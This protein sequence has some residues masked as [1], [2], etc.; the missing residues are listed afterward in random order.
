[1]ATR[2]TKLTIRDI[3]R[4]AGVSR[5]T[6]SLVINRDDRISQGTR[7]HVERV[8]ARSGYEPNALARG[9]ARRRA[10]LVAVVMPRISSRLFSDAYFSEALSGI[11]DELIRQDRR[12]LIEIARSARSEEN[13]CMKL[14]R[15]N[16]VEGMLVLGTL[17]TDAWVRELV[18]SGHPVLL[19][20]SAMRGAV[21]V[22]A[23]NRSGARALVAHLAFL[24][25]RRIAY[26]GGLENTTVGQDRTRGFRAGLRDAGLRAEKRW[27][28]WGD[29]SEESGAVA[30]RR[31][32]ASK[33]HPTAVFAAN[34]AMAIGGL[35]VLRDKGIA[36]P[37]DM[38]LAGADDIQLAAYVSPPLTTL[39]Q[40][41]YEI[42]RLA[43][44]RLQAWTSGRRPGSVI[45]PTEVIGRASAGPPPRA[46]RS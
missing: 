40:P 36:V 34:D 41:M 23:D 31:I 25:H 45:V 6:V 2:G 20:N 39:R 44:Q 10:D 1:M 16:L 42:G 26:I 43:A 30:M 24:G 4:L 5:S 15:E 21:C 38:T 17:T 32:L 9:L 13:R 35:R 33:P 8:I 19:I 28:R 46:R 29:F 27:M 14:F 37:D 18:R 12:I 7:R 22:Q 11:S 3:A